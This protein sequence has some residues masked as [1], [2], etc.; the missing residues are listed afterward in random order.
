M[1]V[2]RVHRVIARPVWLGRVVRLTHAM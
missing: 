2:P 1:L